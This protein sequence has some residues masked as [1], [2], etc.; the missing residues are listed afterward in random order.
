MR[1]L[2]APLL[3][4]PMAAFGRASHSPVMLD[5]AS[6][7]ANPLADP[8]ATGFEVVTLLPQ[9]FW[10]LL[11]FLPNWI[12]TRKL[13]EPIGPLALLALAHLLIV[14]LSTQGSPDVTA[15]LDL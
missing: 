5:A 15:P 1:L 14:V 11:V 8:I 13:F 4:Q 10:L 3:A 12:G 2:T 6:V 9:P 7:L